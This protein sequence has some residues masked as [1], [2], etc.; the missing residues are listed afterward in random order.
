MLHFESDY[1][2]TVH[3]E[4]LEYFA[5]IG[6]KKLTGYG[7]DEICES[8][9]EKIREACGCPDAEIFFLTGGTQSNM[10]VI[11]SL[12]NLYEGVI[13]A[14]T[15]HI[16]THEAG[17]IESSGHKVLPLPNHNGKVAPKEVRALLET[18]YADET[19]EHMVKP[20]MLYVS[21][22]TEYGTLYS[23]SELKELHEICSE[24]KIPLYMD[25]ARLAY[26]LASKDS[27]VSLKDIAEYCD[28]FYIGGTKCGAMMGEAVVFP[29]HLVDGFFTI[30]KQSGAL[31]A[32]GW[33]A[34]AQFDALFTNDL[35]LRCGKNAIDLAE[36]MK[37]ALKEKGYSFYLESP[38]NQQFI[39]LEDEQRK[40]LEEN[41]IM[42]FW[43][44]PD[45]DHTVVRLATSWSTTEEELKELLDIM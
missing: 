7:T 1:I 34:G 2:Q 12:L 28:A 32:K 10:V 20:G 19:H 18:F 23:K 4:I 44:K 33:I 13:A 30:I 8:A 6:D 41:V 43:E 3:P 38:T 40:K 26:A 29:K 45:E 11:R 16:A 21:H 36:K 42:S 27:D 15:G 31:L 14:E 17:A 9:R 37:T 25:G 24:Y 5:S 22:P 39:F 35:Y